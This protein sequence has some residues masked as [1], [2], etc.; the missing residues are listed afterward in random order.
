MIFGSKPFSITSWGKRLTA[1]S[2]GFLD[3][4]RTP[5]YRNATHLVAGTK[6]GSNDEH[7]K[8]QDGLFAKRRRE[9]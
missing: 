1:P 9:N 2:K 6:K 3:D 5:L 4:L 8:K 7:T